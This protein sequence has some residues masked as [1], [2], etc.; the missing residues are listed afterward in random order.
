MSDQTAADTQP[1]GVKTPDVKTSTDVQTSTADPTVPAVGD[2]GPTETPDGATVPPLEDRAT[3]SPALP[4][5][6]PTTEPAPADPSTE[7]DAEP[8]ATD[9]DDEAATLPQT[10]EDAQAE[11]LRMRKWKQ[12]K[13]LEYRNVRDARRT[14]EADATQLRAMH[15]QLTTKHERIASELATAKA[16]REL[17]TTERDAATAVVERHRRA[18]IERFAESDREIAEATPLD[19]L[20]ALHERLVG[21]PL[22]QQPAPPSPTRQPVASKSGS[23]PKPTSFGG[24]FGQE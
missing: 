22:Y 19:L 1:A 16:E 24:Y 5:P 10:L 4:E 14:A 3:S 20:P 21:R 2:S 23:R 11:I 9:D 13:L 6:Q 15:E 7:T 17:A 8:D 12:R 18:I